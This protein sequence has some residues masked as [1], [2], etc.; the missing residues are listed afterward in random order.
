MAIEDLLEMNRSGSEV[1]VDVTNMKL[2]MNHSLCMHSSFYERYRSPRRPRLV[3]NNKHFQQTK[4]PQRRSV[5]STACSISLFKYNHPPPPPPLSL[6][7]SV[8]AEV[9]AAKEFTPCLGINPAMLHRA[10]NS[11]YTGLHNCCKHCTPH[12]KVYLIGGGSVHFSSLSPSLSL[13]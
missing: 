10:N 7:R 8:L 5:V 4:K 13:H 9:A 2:G 6:K 11:K 3:N 1:D 12:S